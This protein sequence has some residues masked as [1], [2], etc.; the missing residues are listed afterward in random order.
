M[1]CS[2][3][4]QAN[5]NDYNFCLKCGKPLKESAVVVNPIP[6]INEPA[7][8]GQLT[9]QQKLY[10][11]QEYDKQSRSPSTALALALLLGGVGAHRLYLRQWG[12]GI[13]Y[14][15]F[16]WTFIPVLVALVECFFIKKR[17]EQ[18]NEK[19]ATTIRQKMNV[20]FSGSE[21]RSRV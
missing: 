2:H 14:V 18:Y 10:F 17:T 1:T 3:C 20:I 8:A 13:A 9:A 6:D 7:Q 5:P 21:I 11:Q 19:V 12:W 4:G 15:I 16:C